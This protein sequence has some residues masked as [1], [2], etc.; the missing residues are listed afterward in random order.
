MPWTKRM[1][2]SGQ[3]LAN[4]KGL[5]RWRNSVYPNGH[6]GRKFIP[7]TQGSPPEAPLGPADQTQTPEA[8]SRA[9]AVT[10]ADAGPTRPGLRSQES[11]GHTRG[12]ET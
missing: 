9:L 7:S 10:V 1:A 2:A 11:R 6:Q 5:P 3:R 8:S 12:P 4:F